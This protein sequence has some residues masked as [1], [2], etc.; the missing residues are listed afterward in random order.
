MQKE[1][2]GKKISHYSFEGK[3]YCPGRSQLEINKSPKRISGYPKKILDTL[4]SRYP[5]SISKEEIISQVWKNNDGNIE[6]FNTHLNTLRNLLEDKKSTDKGSGVKQT[7][8]EIIDSV[9]IGY[10]AIK[11]KVT[12]H[13]FEDEKRRSRLSIY[14]SVAGIALLAIITLTFLLGFA[15]AHYQP[16]NQILLSELKGEFERATL[17]SDERII[18]YT[19]KEPNTKSWSLIANDRQTGRLNWL[20]TEAKPNTHHTEPNLSPSGEQLTW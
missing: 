9:S 8:W 11:P 13:Y 17:S 15:P 14:S 10:L 6:T 3:V 1:R 2:P 4:I 20:V 5:D 16:S 7:H 12:T 18:I 19:F